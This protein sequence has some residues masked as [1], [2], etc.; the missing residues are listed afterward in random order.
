MAIVKNRIVDPNRIL[1]IKF[2]SI[3]DIVLTTSPIK[4]LK[5]AF[6]GAKIDFLTLSSFAPILE[7]NSYI[8]N[9]IPF[10]RNAGL[11]QLIKLVNG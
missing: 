11:S 7:G 6:P 2:S 10:N 3:G 4:S 8:D 1:V 5:L 9:I